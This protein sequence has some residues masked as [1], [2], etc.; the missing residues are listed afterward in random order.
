[1]KIL[2]YFFE[3]I[4]IG[5]LFLFFSLLGLKFSSKLGEI[6]VGTFGPFFRSKK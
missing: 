2:K 6:I 3:F 5:F 4:F 1:M